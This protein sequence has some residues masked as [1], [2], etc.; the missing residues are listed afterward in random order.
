MICWY[1]NTTCRNWRKVSVKG[2]LGLINSP[3]IASAEA[4]STMLHNEIIVTLLP[5]TLA[6]FSL[7]NTKAYLY[8]SLNLLKSFSSSLNPDRRAFRVGMESI[9]LFHYHYSIYKETGVFPA[10]WQTRLL[11]NNPF[12]WRQDA[13]LEQGCKPDLS[14]NSKNLKTQTSSGATPSS[15]Q[16]CSIPSGP[17]LSSPGA[18]NLLNMTSMWSL[19]KDS[20]SYNINTLKL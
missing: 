16:N 5:S 4:T 6:S 18:A 9:L 8:N 17:I 19:W 1:N 11:R 14:L 20:G 3:S 13:K 2:Y 7:A 12:Q 10:Q 15:L